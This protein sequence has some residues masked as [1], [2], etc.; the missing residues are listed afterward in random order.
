MAGEA[1]GR[2]L[3]AGGM[4]GYATGQDASRERFVGE[5]SD[6]RVG[7]CCAGVGA[8]ASGDVVRRSAQA[9]EQAGFSA[10][11]MGEHILLFGAYPE[12]RYPYVGAYG[13]D[14]PIPDPRM[15]IIDPII[16]MTWAAAATERIEVGSGVLILPQRNPVV[17]A[18]A[19][20]SVDEFSG[21]RVVLGAGVGWCKEE[22]DAVGADWPGRG[23]RMDE[24]LAA[25]RALWRDAPAA[26]AGETVSFRDAYCYPR[27]VRGNDIPILIGGESDVA[28]RRVARAGDGWLAFMLPV[29]DAAAR[30]ARL[31]ELTRAQ[32]RDPATLRIIC[33]IFATTPLDDL[34]RYRDAGITEFN[35]VTEVP[36]DPPA[37]AESIADL[38]RRFVDAV[39]DW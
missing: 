30:V 22:Y 4:A 16:G 10:F 23:K 33:G 24:H 13:A 2:R 1:H 8:A 18:K 34:A 27:P 21:G 17:L 26:F 12:S 29:A 6:M 14:V 15:P 32:D 20:A 37:L 5:D 36:T 3:P 19:L 38:G 7:I 31:K 39:A 25:L 9:A 11:W 35:L 28:L